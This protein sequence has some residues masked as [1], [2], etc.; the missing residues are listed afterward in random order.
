MTPPRA[1]WISAADAARLLGVTRP[2]LYAYVSRGYVRSQ[3]APGRHRERMY[4][5][6][7]VERLRQRAAHRRD[8]EHA[9]G[10]ALQ[11]GLPV[12]ESA[13]TL[14]D[15]RHVYYRGEDAIALAT[16]RSVEEVAAL[17]WTGEMSRTLPA[18]RDAAWTQNR[19][20][21]T[22]FIARAQSMLAAAASRDPAPFDQRVDALVRT[23][24]RIVWLLTSAAVGRV[25]RVGG[26]DAVLS[27]AWNRGDPRAASIVRAAL[28]LC[29]D[30]ELNVSSFTA[31]CV[32]STGSHLYAVVM[33]GL[34]AL[35]GPRHGGA[36]ARVDAMLESLRDS[37]S[38]HHAV[39]ARLRRGEPLDGF[40]HPLY[41]D[42]DPRAA[43]LLGLL[44]QH[45]GGSPEYRYV[46][47]FAKI[48]SAAIGQ[49]PNLDFALASTVRVLRLPAG[50]PLVLFAVGRSIGWIGH[51]MEQYA[52]GQLI[53]P[54]AK[55]VGLAP[56]REKALSSTPRSRE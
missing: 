53:R 20:P 19:G 42:G 45:F 36:S 25:R 2:T 23:G 56:G 35:E 51:A 40:G 33:A 39:A 15:G 27:R 48:A 6:D 26:V 21:R 5:G 41:N 34:A 32:A 9:A 55:Y 43:A 24:W 50:T 30:H 1:S 12:L 3:V 16:G 28:I 7:D 22:P 18:P 29:A 47:Q 37:R 54:R 13:I 44:H 46:A 38:L 11:W 10:H 49:Q 8:P 31:R 52:A 17:I 14:I 4:S